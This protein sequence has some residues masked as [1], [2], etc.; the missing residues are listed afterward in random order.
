MV[1]EQPDAGALLD[2]ARAAT[3]SGDYQRASELLTESGRADT[4]GQ[5]SP[6]RDEAFRALV[7]AI[8]RAD[9]WSPEDYAVDLMRSAYETAVQAAVDDASKGVEALSDAARGVGRLAPLMGQETSAQFDAAIGYQS[10][11]ALRSLGRRDEAVAAY[12]GVAERHSG[13]SDPHVQYWLGMCLVNGA[14][15]L[16]QPENAVEHPAV[17]RHAFALVDQM[18]DE[19]GASAVPEIR[20][21]LVRAAALEVS[22]LVSIG[23]LAEASEAFQR[24]EPH[25]A[26]DDAETRGD[27][28]RWRCVVGQPDD[29]AL[30]EDLLRACALDDDTWQGLEWLAQGADAE[31]VASAKPELLTDRV[32]ALLD[33][34]AT[35]LSEAEA[36]ILRRDREKL[37]PLAERGPKPS[38]DGPIE[39]LAWG[40][41]VRFSLETACDIARRPKVVRTL[42]QPYVD[43]LC[44]L[45]GSQLEQGDWRRAWQ[46]AM[47]LR[48]AAERLPAGEQRD[49]MT[50]GIG[51][52]VLRV[53]ETAWAAVPDRRTYDTALAVGEEMFALGAQYGDAVFTGT[54]HESLGR[55]LLAPYV[56]DGM[57]D[58]QYF[59]SVRRWMDRLGEE[60]TNQAVD[61][62]PDRWE[63]PKFAD[64]LVR[65]EKHALAAVEALPAEYSVGARVLLQDVHASRKR[66]A[67][68][69]DADAHV[70]AAEAMMEVLGGRYLVSPDIAMRALLH[71]RSLGWGVTHETLTTV[72]GTSMKMLREDW[73]D[74]V[75]RRCLLPASLL[76]LG[77]DRDW[78][79]RLLDEHR[80]LVDSAEEDL[81]LRLLRMEWILIT[82]P[83]SELDMEDLA[84][85]PIEQKLTLIDE[86]ARSRK[87]PE[88]E[89]SRVRLLAASLRLEIG[90]DGTD[91][92]SALLDLWA[93][94]AQTLVGDHGSAME[95]NVASLVADMSTRAMKR[96]DWATA[97]AW[98]GQ[99]IEAFLD[100]HAP[101]AALEGLTLVDYSCG[102]SE[103][104]L[105]R[106]I[107][108]VLYPLALR[109]DLELGPRATRLM[110]GIWQRALQ[111]EIRSGHGDGAVLLALLQLSKG[112]RFAAAWRAG[113]AVDV[114]EDPTAADLLTQVQQSQSQIEALGGDDPDDS[115]E[116]A[117]VRL[118]DITLVTAYDEE[119][120]PLPNPTTTDLLE[121]LQ[122]SFDARAQRLALGSEGN[123]ELIFE[124]ELLE[125]VPESS[126]LLL[127]TFGRDMEDKP[128]F[129]WLLAAPGKPLTFGTQPVLGAQHL[130]VESEGRRRVLDPV[131]TVAWGIRSAVQR[132]PAGKALN[133]AER[134]S[135]DH[136][137]DTML[138]PGVGALRDLLEEGLSHL[139][140]VPHGGLHF[141]PFA[142]LHLDG[143]PLV[144]RLTVTTLP[145][146]ALLRP[147]PRVERAEE[148]RAIGVDFADGM[149]G[150]PPLPE[151]VTEAGAVAHLFGAEPL[152]PPDAT[153]SAMVSALQ[154]ATYV[155]LATHGEHAVPAP[156]FQRVYAI[157]SETDDGRLAAY[158]LM[159]ADLGG[160]RLLTLSACE[161]A[162]GRFDV[163]D[164]MLGVP[165]VLLLRGA[166]TVVGTLWQVETTVSEDFFVALY[167]GLHAGLP[168]GDAF[169]QAQREVR[170]THPQYR[171][172]AAFQLVGDWR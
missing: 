96:G 87:W 134:S 24:F 52:A 148:I 154:T 51:L 120:D 114:T 170:R 12:D 138:G 38:L 124:E 128:S 140:V 157:P 100:L 71:L 70:A 118:D 68:E 31:D 117:G 127:V 21:R 17:R 161:T 1:S 81:R 136:A 59:P 10:A 77:V 28:E 14:Q 167:G 55:M 142:A 36:G 26:S 121:N 162:L 99:T 23:R 3:D 93:E 67:L 73:G 122:R 101:D 85:G 43:V 9:G 95:G 19:L 104:S 84:S 8:A 49:L 66:W 113:E 78:G 160:L 130:V 135:V 29:G 168:R 144:E 44:A 153:E 94:E 115:E 7:T 165:A 125:L 16:L 126:A 88:V 131:A 37:G 155:H 109:L 119:L 132:D 25:L 159:R 46:L 62:E 45:C 139:V 4:D 11:A 20:V 56:R 110:Q 72:L 60:V 169:A 42:A 80:D 146:L 150:L 47:V 82:S 158:E 92:E 116:S 33:E 149:F 141:V 108:E 143:R 102:E 166:E 75:V 61:P 97:I 64:D 65:A 106:P 91:D 6:A 83:R 98:H 50:I 105:G 89:R 69:P 63:I 54:V 30:S 156:S 107:I 32:A 34:A 145:N 48:A 74:A 58:V 76:S 171:D 79:L 111:R 41:G 2:R 90:A 35:E 123:H 172:W 39:G 137:L 40:V 57:G 112:F 86:W 27:F 151:A 53:A 133:P 103:E 13:S 15:L 152:L 5:L 129:L 163:A 22:S 18:F 164:N 147:R